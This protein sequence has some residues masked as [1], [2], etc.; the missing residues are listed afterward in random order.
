MS[1]EILVIIHSEGCCHSLQITEDHAHHVH[2]VH[3]VNRE[4]ILT[5]GL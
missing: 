1:P 5:F 2:H 3:Y 4:T